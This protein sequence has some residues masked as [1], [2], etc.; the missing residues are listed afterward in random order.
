MTAPLHS[1][2]K[3]TN[4]SFRLPHEPLFPIENTPFFERTGIVAVPEKVNGSRYQFFST[5]LI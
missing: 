3:K 2:P 1:R 5:I 4:A